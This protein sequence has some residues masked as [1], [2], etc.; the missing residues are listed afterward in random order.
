MSTSRLVSV[1]VTTFNRVEM[2]LLTVQ[3]I[4][5]QTY[6][7]I[8]VIIIDDESNDL[9]EQKVK[10][11]E[12]DRVFYYKI[13]HWGG[14]ARPRNVGIE[15][16][17]GYYIC[18]CDDDDLWEKCKVEKSIE[19]MFQKGAEIVFT[20]T[21]F[22]DQ[23]G[24]SV[25]KKSVFSKNVFMNFQVLKKRSKKLLINNMIPLS[26]VI[27]KKDVVSD[28][29]FPEDKSLISQEDH[30]LWILLN[31]NSKFHYLD[32]NLVQYRLHVGGI[33]KQKGRRRKVFNHKANEL[34]KE[35]IITYSDYMI[36]RI[37]FEI[38]EIIK[39]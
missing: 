28:L 6:S 27:L 5:D 18:F 24:N 9:T 26:S 12:D 35:N 29:K 30:Y 7:N 8:E 13:N 36:M 22:I 2:L 21:S 23:F 39:N 3:S 37:I 14:P 10:Q 31:Q 32:S 20:G 17:N 19:Y 34:K 1:I 15:K 38:K 4:L 25:E 16:S 11:I 33:S